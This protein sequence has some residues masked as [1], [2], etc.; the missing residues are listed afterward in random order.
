MRKATIALLLM[1]VLA[2]QQLVARD[3][4][5][6]ASPPASMG[7]TTGIPAPDFELEQLDGGTV[8]LKDLQGKIVLLNFWATWCVPCREEMPLLSQIYREYH[9]QGLE[10]LGVN[11]TSQD[12]F[13]AV[14]SFVQEFDLP[15]PI[16]LDHNARVERAYQIFGVPTTV[17]ITREGMIHQVVVGVLKGREEVEKTIRPLLSR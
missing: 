17:F 10:I 1:P 13:A 15:F 3:S 4:N 12:D 8:R 11:L 16:L 7:L 14:R 6:A 9:S 5:P 2:C